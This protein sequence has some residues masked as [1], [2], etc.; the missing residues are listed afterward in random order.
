MNAL[1]RTLLYFNNCLLEYCF[2]NIYTLIMKAL[3]YPL[4]PFTKYLTDFLL[5]ILFILITSSAKN[6]LLLMYFI[7]LSAKKAFIFYH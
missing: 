3:R 2:S 7:D 4:H 1:Q 6:V 5:Y